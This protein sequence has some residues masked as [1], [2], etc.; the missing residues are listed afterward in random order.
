VQD[1]IDR[2]AAAQKDAQKAGSGV[3]VRNSIGRDS[4]TRRVRPVLKCFALF[5]I[6]GCRG[7]ISVTERVGVIVASERWRGCGEGLRGPA[8][9]EQLP[10]KRR[11]R[12]SMP[13][14]L[15]EIGTEEIPARM[16][17]AAW[18]NCARGRQIA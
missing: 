18:R 10:M 7:A 14:F 16:I 1:L 9:R 6:L 12:S 8:E 5:N 13:D 17:D 11:L 4:G 3:A 2:Y 15:L